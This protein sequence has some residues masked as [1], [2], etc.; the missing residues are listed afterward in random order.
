MSWAYSYLP[1]Q[2]DSAGRF[3]AWLVAA[4]MFLAGVAFTGAVYVESLIATWN[5]NVSGTLTLQVPVE[6]GAEMAERALAKLR[7]LPQVAAAQIV[8]RGKVNALLEPWLGSSAAITELPLPT[9]IDVSLTEP[10]TAA[11]QIVGNAIKQEMPEIVVDDHRAWLNRIVSLAEAFRWLA[12]AMFAMVIVALALTV[13]FATKASL[14]EA[15][16]IVET[17]HLVG[18][19]DGYVAAQFSRR[20]AAQTLLGAVCGMVAFLPA[21]WVL[22]FLAGRIDTGILPDVALPWMFWAGLGG[23]PVVATALA[24]LTAHVTVRRLLA[25]MI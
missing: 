5:A 16:A 22:R 21:I 12:A 20:A 17:L 1:K 23:L 14:V 15:S 2:S 24:A 9:L 4:F 25:R 7:A 18:A 3:T 11:A 6:R 8:P 19:K 10:T 13:I